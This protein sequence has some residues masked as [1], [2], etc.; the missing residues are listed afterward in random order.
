LSNLIVDNRYTA[1]EQETIDKSL[2]CDIEKVLNTLDDK[3]AEIIRCRYGLG[4][5]KP[6]SLVEI[7]ER[8]NLTKERIRQIEQKALVRL[9]FPSR[10]SKLEAYVA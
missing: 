10:K 3:E 7:G 8:F 2:K 6:M 5:N 9:Q 1:P 4:H